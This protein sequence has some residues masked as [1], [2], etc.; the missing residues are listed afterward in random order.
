[1]KYTWPNKYK[2]NLFQSAELNGKISVKLSSNYE[3]ELF[4]FALYNFRRRNKLGHERFQNYQISVFE[5]QL[6]IHK[7]IEAEITEIEKEEAVA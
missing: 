2:L 5:N 3:A 7:S 6:T 1:M 4:R